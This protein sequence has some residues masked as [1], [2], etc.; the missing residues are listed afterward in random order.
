MVRFEG[1]VDEFST[2]AI[3]PVLKANRFREIFLGIFHGFLMDSE[4]D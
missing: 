4:V 1:T 2:Q 3:N